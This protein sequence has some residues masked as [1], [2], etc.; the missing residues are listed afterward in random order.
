VAVEISSD[1]IESSR[2]LCAVVASLGSDTD[3]AVQAEGGSPVAWW[4]I[5]HNR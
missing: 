1:S 2:E 4:R 3:G 5:N